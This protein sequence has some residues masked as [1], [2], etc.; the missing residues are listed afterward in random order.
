MHLELPNVRLQS[1][2]DFLKHYLMIVLSILTAL[3]LEADMTKGGLGTRSRRFS[4]IVE[5]GTVKALNI[6]DAPGQAVASGA[7]ALMEQL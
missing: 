5:D 6:E 4:M 2:R 3:G 1:V 7:A